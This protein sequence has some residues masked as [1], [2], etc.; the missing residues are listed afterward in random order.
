MRGGPTEYT[1]DA[2]LVHLDDIEP[3][4]QVPC[5]RRQLQV[6]LSSLVLVACAQEAAFA[7]LVVYGKLDPKYATRVAGEA[8]SRHRSPE[9]LDKLVAE[10]TPAE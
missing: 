7:A 2:L 6:R 9:Y 1:I 10:L 3:S 4:I 5:A 8:R